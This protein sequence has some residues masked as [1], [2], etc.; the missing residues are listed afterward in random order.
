[1]RAPAV[2]LALGAACG[3]GGGNPGATPDA[4]TGPD[5]GASDNAGPPNV[6]LVIADDFGV[7]SSP[8]YDD[9]DQKPSMPTLEGLC[10]AGV[11]F[12]HAWAA[13]EC[14]PTRSSMITG[15]PGFATGVGAAG[16]RL[17]P[18]VTSLMDVIT[19]GSPYPY[20]S[21]V[22]GKWHL[23][24]TGNTDYSHPAE[25]GVEYYTGVFIGALPDYYHWTKIEDGAP[26]AVDEYAT[27][28]FTDDAIAWIG[29]QD[30]PWF[31]WL[32]YTAPHE[33]LHLPPAE[34]IDR[35]DLTGTT[36]DIAARPRDYYFAAA[37]AMDAELGRLLDQM[38]DDV[39]A[40]TVILF[41]G[42]N[43]TPGRM[44]QPP[45]D[46]DRAKGSLYE[47]GIRVPLVIAGPPV[48]RPGARES[49]LVASTDLFATIAELTGA[50]N[51]RGDTSVSLLQY[52]AEAAEPA[53]AVVYSEYFRGGTPQSTDDPAAFGWTVRDDHLQMIELDSGDRMLFDLDGDPGALDDLASSPDHAGD[54]ERLE[55]AGR[56]LRGE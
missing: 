20:S 32:A 47:G 41:L 16:D 51:P 33:P 2:L 9:G 27:T 24:G 7:D 15:L 43:G 29:D 3:G 45:Y 31:L 1:M 54:L 8:C 48:R 25:L 55:A 12:E 23:A 13:P 5:A 56:S 22:I 30:G 50:A 36:A 19:D 4:G 28:T 17:D 37:E 10:A 14:S 11:V 21:A 38:P 35:P 49:A 46:A 39:R 34:L 40:N 42:D 53:R 52:L 26:V 6:L 44:A 18:D